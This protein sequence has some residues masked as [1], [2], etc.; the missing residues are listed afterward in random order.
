MILEGCSGG[1]GGA[2]LDVFGIDEKKVL[3]GFGDEGV[4][5]GEDSWVE[6]RGPNGLFRVTL[7][8]LPMI[9]PSESD[10]IY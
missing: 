10:L 1:I 8:G 2:G 5:G 6:E 4:K 3:S 9:L 7:T